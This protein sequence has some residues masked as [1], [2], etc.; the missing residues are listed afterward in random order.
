MLGGLLLSNHVSF[1]PVH[2]KTIG[3]PRLAKILLH[4]RTVLVLV[5]LGFS[6][7]LL[8]HWTGAPGPGKPREQGRRRQEEY[9]DRKGMRV[10]VGHYIEDEGPGP[11][12]T[13]EEL[14]LNR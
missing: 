6:S 2:N 1:T 11:N 7:L 8:L 4:R 14:N 3:M 5:V 10:I 12:F 13:K 9:V